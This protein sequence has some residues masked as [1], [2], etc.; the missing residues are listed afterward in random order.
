[1]QNFTRKPYEKSLSPHSNQKQSSTKI[2]SAI[3]PVKPISEKS[4]EEMDCEGDPDVS[5]KRRK[6]ENPL[7]EITRNFIDLIARAPLQQINLNEAA[8]TLG[9]SKRRIYDITNVLEGIGFIE[10]SK[11]NTIKLVTDHNIISSNLKEDPKS[12]VFTEL[13]KEEQNLFSLIEATANE[14]NELKNSEEYLRNGYVTNEDIMQ[15]PEFNGEAVA[16]QAS[17]GTT[18]EL[19]EEND[20]K[21]YEILLKSKE[22]ILVHKIKQANEEK[23]QLLLGNSDNSI[24]KMI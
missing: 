22:E 4:F 19:I 8:T 10:K 21:D 15:R 24:S 9:V 6:A 23:N 11:K 18:L 12:K 17:E 13:E 5:G 7:Q 16:I 20:Q 1:M 3:S 2:K 14:L